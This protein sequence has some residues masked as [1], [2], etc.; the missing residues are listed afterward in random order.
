LQ[1][2]NNLAAQNPDKLKELQG[3]FE[4]GR[5]GGHALLLMDG[6]PEF[7]YALS[8]QKELKYC[9][10]S[11]EKLAA[12]KHTLKVD[13]KY[14]GPG[15]GKSATAT[16]FV[17]GEQVAQGKIEHTIPVRFSLDETFDVGMDTGTPV[18]ENYVTK[19]PFKFTGTLDKVIIE[20][21]K[22]GLTA[23]DELKL[24]ELNKEAVVATE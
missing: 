6:K 7:A 10:V 8:N 13:M 9:V 14:E 23:S 21:G 4:D 18:V 17:D 22:S 20:L 24:E 16:L 2:A 15:Y 12:G 11:K 1:Q 19:M 5:F 3:L